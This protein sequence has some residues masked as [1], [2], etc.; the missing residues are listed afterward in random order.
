MHP[1]IRQV[2]TS[3]ALLVLLSAIADTL[4]FSTHDVAGGLYMSLFMWTPGLAA[5]ITCAVHRL[6]L[7]DI[8]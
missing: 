8:G 6:D 1:P 3:L 4:L 5:L 2:F 7:R